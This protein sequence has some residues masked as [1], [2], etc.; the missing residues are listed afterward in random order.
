[1]LIDWIRW[2]QT[3]KYSALGQSGPADLRSVRAPR[4][5]AN[6]FTVRHSH[7]VNKYTILQWCCVENLTGFSF[8]REEVMTT[9]LRTM[10]ATDSSTIFRKD[11][12]FSPFEKHCE[13]MVFIGMLLDTDLLFKDSQQKQMDDHLI[14]FAATVVESKLSGVCNW[15]LICLFTSWFALAKRKVIVRKII[16]F[17]NL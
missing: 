17:R 15:H 11:E 3:G 8:S 10:I 12:W 9:K 13:Y 16:R 1:M 5:R 2:G 4:P 6:Y 14:W 7:S